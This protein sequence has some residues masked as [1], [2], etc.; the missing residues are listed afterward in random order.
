M[1]SFKNDYSEGCHPKILEALIASNEKQMAGYGLDDIT[2]ETIELLRDRMAH[3]EVDIHLLSGG[4]Q[5]NL[6]ALSHFM[7]PHE[8]VISPSSGHIMT[9]EAGSIEA[10][11]HK[12]IH[13]DTKNGKISASQV[14]ATLD[15]YTDEHHVKPKVVYISNS[16]E[17]GTIY[18]KQELTELYQMCQKYKLYLF[19]DGARLGSALTS[20][21]NDLTLKD[22][23][24]LTDAFYIG[25]TKNGA[26]L[27]EALVISNDDLKAEMRYNI[28][29]KGALLAKGRVVATQF[30]TLFKDNLFFD[31][32]KHANEM[33][34]LLRDGLE[35]KGY[36]F[37]SPSST[38]QVFP[39]VSSEVIEKLETEFEF[40]K[41]AKV[42]SSNYALRLVTSF[43]TPKEAVEK[44]IDLL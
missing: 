20:A 29:Q 19:V 14:E 9:N 10:T 38:N 44:F 42:D 34:D 31:L 2:L 32:A 40:Y 25:G 28:K 5:T 41:W 17:I 7:R 37:F 22:M 6:I 12:V 24:Y 33:A 4:T 39:I 16:T 1:Y 3:K 18:S 30:H 35:K 15:K 26:L 13:I 27:G 8:A 11:G 23:A 43:A 21:N 36:T